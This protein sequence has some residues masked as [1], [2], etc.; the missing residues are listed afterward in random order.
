MEAMNTNLLL[1]LQ[2]IRQGNRI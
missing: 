2:E 1:L